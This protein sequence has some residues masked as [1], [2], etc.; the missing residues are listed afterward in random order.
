MDNLISLENEHLIYKKKKQEI[1]SDADKTVLNGKYKQAQR[2]LLP[3][4]VFSHIMPKNWF[5]LF[6]LFQLRKKYTKLIFH[7]PWWYQ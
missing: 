4:A 1:F 3:G 7:M 6:P 2:H 5:L